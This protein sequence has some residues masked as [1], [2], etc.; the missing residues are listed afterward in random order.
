MTKA[1]KHI[2]ELSMENVVEEKIFFIKNIIIDK[3]LM[4]EY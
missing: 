4:T 2:K 3:N 1:L